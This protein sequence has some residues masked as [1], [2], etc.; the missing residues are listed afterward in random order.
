MSLSPQISHQSDVLDGS[1]PILEAEH[2]S[3]VFPVRQGNP[4]GKRLGVHAVENASIALYPGRVTALVGESGSGKTTIAR[5]LARIYDP[6]SG[7]IRFQGQP[8]TFQGGSA[9][10][11]YRRHV[12]LVFQDPFASLNPVH[13][14]RYTISRPLRVYGHAHNQAE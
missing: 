13:G 8:I 14:I 6:T 10:R 9:L 11:N 4:F 12:Q 2:I 7:T 3:K 1:M 5:M